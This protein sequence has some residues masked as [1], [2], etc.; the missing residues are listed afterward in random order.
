MKYAL[1]MV[2]G[3]IINRVSFYDDPSLAIAVL[4]DHIKEMDLERDDAA[5]NC[6]NCEALV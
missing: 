3:G 4:A 5:G 1:I 2:S 6:G